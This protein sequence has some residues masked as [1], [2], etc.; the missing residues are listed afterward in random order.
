MTI[1][2]IPLVQDNG[3]DSEEEPIPKRKHQ[4]YQFLLRPKAD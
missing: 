2:A 3:S 1:L 4:Y